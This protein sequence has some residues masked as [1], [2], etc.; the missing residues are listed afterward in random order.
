MGW[1]IQSSENDRRINSVLRSLVWALRCSQAHVCRCKCT[2]TFEWCKM[3]VPMS[4][5]QNRQEGIEFNKILVTTIVNSAK[6]TEFSFPSMH[7]SI[8][9]LHRLSE[10][11][12]MG[13]T[14]TNRLKVCDISCEWYVYWTDFI[15]GSFQTPT[16]GNTGYF[17]SD[18]WGGDIRVSGI[19]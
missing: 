16:F 18:D 4:E 13:F 5:L 6:Y 19:F 9:P 14:H 3:V 2:G 12:C 1:H 7:S 11:M 15:I 8:L 17:W 10:T